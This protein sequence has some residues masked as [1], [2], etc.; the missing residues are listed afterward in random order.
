MQPKSEK[1]FFVSGI[2]AS[3]LVSL[4]CSC[5]EKDTSYRQPMCELAVPRFCISQRESFP[6]SVSLAVID[7]NAKV[8]VMQISTVPGH[9]YHET[10]LFRHSSEYVLGKYK[11]RKYKF[12]EGHLCIQNL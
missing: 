4:N 3:E 10:A 7:E 1:M 9:V 6:D 11:L 5:Q 8:G 2:I 12:Y